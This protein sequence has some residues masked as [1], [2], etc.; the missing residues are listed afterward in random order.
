M[1]LEVRPVF[2]CV[3]RRSHSSAE[4]SPQ[5]NRESDIQQDVSA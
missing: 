2:I 5:S 1:R 3:V 4:S